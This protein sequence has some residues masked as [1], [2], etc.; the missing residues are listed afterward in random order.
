MYW[1]ETL[2]K[3]TKYDV[4]SPEEAVE[5]YL[6]SIQADYSFNVEVLVHCPDGTS[7]LIHGY[8]GCFRSGIEGPYICNATFEK[9]TS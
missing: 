2:S 6:Y 1:V 5:E 3:C 7:T 9:R 8:F 4:N